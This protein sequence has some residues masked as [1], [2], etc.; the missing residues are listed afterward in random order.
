[1]VGQYVSIAE[2]KGITLQAISSGALV[3][4]DEYRLVQILNNMVSNA[5][6][7]SPPNTITTL[8]T[9]LRDD[10]YFVCVRDQ[11]PG[12]PTH[13][14]ESLF[15]PFQRGSNNPTADETSSGL[16][17]WIV[18]EMAEQQKGVVGVECPAE[19]GSVF[20]VRLPVVITAG[21]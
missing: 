1:M 3:V 8:Y 4:A 21:V 9:D 19:G 18:R 12:I 13:E 11:G 2:Q 15:E 16:G 17:L 5:I 6:K 10:D 20:W 14:Q 7:Y